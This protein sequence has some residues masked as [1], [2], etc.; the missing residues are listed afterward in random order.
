TAPG[1]FAA[2]QAAPLGAGTIGGVNL[3]IDALLLKPSTRPVYAAVFN[4][5]GTLDQGWIKLTEGLFSDLGDTTGK[6]VLYAIGKSGKDNPN[7]DINFD[8]FTASPGPFESIA[9]SI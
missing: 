6:T 8:F 2:I 5:D 4:E 3:G 7:N 1:G 9:L